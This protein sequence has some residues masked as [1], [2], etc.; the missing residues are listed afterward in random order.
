MKTPTGFNPLPHMSN[1]R[2]SNSAANE[3]MMS[4]IWTNRDTIT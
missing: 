2:S 4:K 1:V 3:D